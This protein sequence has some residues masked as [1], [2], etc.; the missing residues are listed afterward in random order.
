M[1]KIQSNIRIFIN[2]CCD[3]KLS[4][5]HFPGG[6]PI[7]LARNDIPSLFGKHNTTHHEYCLS[8]KADGIN[9]GRYFLGFL[10]IEGEFYSFLVDR[11]FKIVIIPA[12]AYPTA[13][14]GTLFDVEFLQTRDLDVL[15]LIFDTICMHGNSTKDCFYPTRL[16]F[17][18]AFLQKHTQFEKTAKTSQIPRGPMTYASNFPDYIVDFC[19]LSDRI[20]R[21]KT[22]QIYYVQ[23][24]G[25]MHGTIYDN[26]GFIWTSASLPYA[27]FRTEPT[28]IIKWKPPSCITIDF[29]LKK[30]S[31][32]DVWENIFGIPDKYRSRCGSCSLFTQ[33]AG[34]A[35]L[36]AKIDTTETPGIY[37]IRWKHER[38][39][40]VKERTDK[41]KPNHLL[42]VSKT[43]ENIQQKI[44]IAE[45]CSHF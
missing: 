25:N 4:N 24:I 3:V 22:K 15:L 9:G 23:N 33:D 12:V 32:E 34:K 43:I 17:A 38:W 11:N 13:Y 10:A 20:C 36:F 6:L 5:T 1:E 44:S 37:E 40:I 30:S 39:E 41:S 7:S 42:T 26:D 16:E 28:A 18:R 14:E 35:I 2:K 31:Q 19:R 8:Y 29:E 27:I 45:I 21:L